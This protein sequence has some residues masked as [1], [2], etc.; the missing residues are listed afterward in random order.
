[1][2][3]AAGSIDVEDLRRRLAARGLG[4][5]EAESG[6]HVLNPD[7]E[8]L[9]EGPS[10]REAAVLVPVVDRPA[11][12]SVIL[13]TRA[14]SLRQHSG[15]IAFPGGSVDPGDASIEVAALR[16]AREEIGLDSAHVE[17]VGRLPRYRTTTGFRI[18]PVLGIVSPGFSLRPDPAEVADIFEVPLAFLMD[19]TNHTRDSRVWQGH[20]RHFYTM[21]FGERYIWGVTA[22]ILRTLYERLY[23]T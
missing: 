8:Q 7:I 1:M 9:T 21:P 18:T 17:L 22:G 4:A 2:R 3:D 16:E 12:A 13:T 14:A 10:V 19:G 11:G 20:I 23:A 15:Q 6:D 5:L